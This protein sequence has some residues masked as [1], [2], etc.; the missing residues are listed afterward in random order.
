MDDDGDNYHVRDTIIRSPAT[1]CR[2]TSRN[3]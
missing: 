1:A 3:A 2:R